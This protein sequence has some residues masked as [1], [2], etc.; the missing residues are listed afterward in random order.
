MPEKPSPA[1]ICLECLQSATVYKFTYQS[2]GCYS[3]LTQAHSRPFDTLSVS[4]YL[5]SQYLEDFG[6]GPIVNGFLRFLLW[7]Q[8]NGFFLSLHRQFQTLPHKLNFE[9]NSLMPYFLIRGDSIPIY[10]PVGKLVVE[11]QA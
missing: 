5:F 10:L 2:I 7:K 4:S 9:A 1:T 6:F 8:C 11:L 3:F